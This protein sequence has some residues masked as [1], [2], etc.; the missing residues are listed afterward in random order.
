[1]TDYLVLT[2][3]VNDLDRQTEFWTAALSYEVAGG[4][5]QYRALTD[6]S[7]RLPKLLLQTVD[8]AKGA[9]NR[10]HLD[11]HVPDIEAEAARL[12]SVGATRVERFDEFGISWVLMTDPE[13]NEFCVCPA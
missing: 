3:D 1:M 12:E 11:L 10:L 7:G 5:G 4:V 13:G 6:P 9:K 8:E 2:L